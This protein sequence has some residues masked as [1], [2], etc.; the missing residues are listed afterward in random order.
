MAALF[1]KPAFG[2]VLVT[3]RAGTISAGVIRVDFPLA[4]IAL[5]DVASEERR[6][7]GG[8]IPQSPVLDRAQ[9]DA[10]LLAIRRTVEADDI[11]HLEHED[12]G[13]RGRS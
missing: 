8:N 5:M 11:G 13:L 12:P 9:A 2:L 7:A 10:G 4:V 6:A 3:L 1:F